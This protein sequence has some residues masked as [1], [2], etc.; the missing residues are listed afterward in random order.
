MSG[1]DNNPIL[2]TRQ[3]HPVIDNLC[4]ALVTGAPFVDLHLASASV[5]EGVL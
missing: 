1:Q 2:T 4:E 3:G 5:R